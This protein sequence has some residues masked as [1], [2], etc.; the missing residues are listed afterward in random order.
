MYDEF[1]DRMK[2]YEAVTTSRKAFKGQPLLVRLDGNS[3]STFTRGLQRPY[4]ERMT[5]L[6]IETMKA[7]VEKFNPNLGY[8]QSD[9]ISLVFLT[10]TNDPGDLPFAGRIQKLESLTASFA[11]VYFNSRLAEF[12]PEKVGLLPIFDS[13]AFVVPTE[14][15]AYNELL[16]R[17]QDCQKNAISMAAQAFFSPKELHGKNG[18]EKI[19][20]LA[21]VGVDFS[22]YPA[23]FQRGTFA[24]REEVV[25]H[26]TPAEAEKIP[27]KYRP[28]EPIKRSTIVE[29]D[30]CWKAQDDPRV[31]L[32]GGSIAPA[33]SLVIDTSEQPN[34]AL[35]SAFAR[36]MER[37]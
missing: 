27:E 23:A 4:D 28:T 11:S 6:M 2:S 34:E 22:K 25:R 24:R 33:S 32:Y 19:K 17:Q 29:H 36:R 31:V 3:F 5:R 37:E 21:S 13:R 35:I 16:W 26:L 20:M 9:E 18:L 14:I 8:V 12:L 15:E 7:L 1:G 30:I 10:K